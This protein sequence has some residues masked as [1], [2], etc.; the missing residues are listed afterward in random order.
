MDGFWSLVGC[1]PQDHK[2]SDT[3]SERLNLLFIVPL[4]GYLLQESFL[5]VPVPQELIIELISSLS[6]SLFTLKP[7]YQLQADHADV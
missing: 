5:I 2:E 1:S 6:D 4:Q 7:F 3:L